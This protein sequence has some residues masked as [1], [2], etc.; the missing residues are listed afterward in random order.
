MP[1]RRISTRASSVTR[2]QTAVAN[3]HPEASVQQ[4]GEAQPEP[5]VR[6]RQHDEFVTPPQTLISLPPSI[7]RNIFQVNN[8]LENRQNG[9]NHGDGDDDG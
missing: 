5:G 6:P 3:S 7:R 8:R 4:D 9:S 2:G 1:S